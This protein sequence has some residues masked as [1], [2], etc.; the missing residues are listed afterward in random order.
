MPGGAHDGGEN[1]HS[2]A[3]ASVMI[4]P[5]LLM[6]LKWCGV[7][8]H[9]L[10]ITGSCEAVLKAR[11]PGAVRRCKARRPGSGL[12]RRRA[13]IMHQSQNISCL[14]SL[15]AHYCPLTGYS[16][17]PILLHGHC[18]AYFRGTN[19][20]WSHTRMP[21][22]TAIVQIDPRCALPRPPGVGMCHSCRDCIWLLPL[23]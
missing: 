21:A 16:D 22:H 10:D 1:R 19:S 5:V 3:H 7:W 17:S 8:T 23:M 4:R 6:M 11:R 13:L 15:T 14:P 20:R 9:I 12:R 2:G 18:P